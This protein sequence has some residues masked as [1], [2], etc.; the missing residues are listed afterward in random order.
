MPL[1]HSCRFHQHHDREA[2]R[3][4]SVQQSPEKPI[5]STDTGSAG[6]LAPKHGQLVPEGH[7]LK[8]EGASAAKPAGEHRNE[9]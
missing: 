2:L 7:H 4:E 9:G 3:P 5:P 6:V 1:D 8:F